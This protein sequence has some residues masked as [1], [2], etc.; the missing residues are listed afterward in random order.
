MTRNGLMV[1]GFIIIL[2]AIVASAAITDKTSCKRGIKGRES[3]IA[4]RSGFEA[5][6]HGRYLK[7]S[8][9]PD[10]LLAAEERREGAGLYHFARQITVKPPNCS[11]LFPG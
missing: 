4:L 6:A 7:A 10:P 8:H 1:A 5:S 11:G 2:L 3:L 9:Q